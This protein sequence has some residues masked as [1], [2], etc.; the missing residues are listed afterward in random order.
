MCTD[1]LSACS[2]FRLSGRLWLVVESHNSSPGLNMSLV[3]PSFLMD[4]SNYSQ[5]RDVRVNFHLDIVGRMKLFNCFTAYYNDYFI[6]MILLKY[7]S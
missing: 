1:G 3:W 4:S 2:G 7:K 6:H 5:W